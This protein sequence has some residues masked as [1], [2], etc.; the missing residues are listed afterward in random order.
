MSSLFFAWCMGFIA[1]A[2]V[3]VIGAS[4]ALAAMGHQRHT[5]AQL[6]AGVM[7]ADAVVVTISL[8]TLSYAPQLSW[9]VVQGWWWLWWPLIM[10]LAAYGVWLLIFPR[11]M[12]QQVLQPQ[13]PFWWALGWTLGANPKNWL[14]TFALLAGWH[15][16]GL[17]P[18][19]ADKLFFA[20][21]L[22]SGGLAAWCLWAWLCWQQQRWRQQAAQLSQRLV[23]ILCLIAAMSATF[24]L[25]FA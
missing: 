23:G 18:T 2:P 5:L 14:G 15:G 3:G 11:A 1:A 8:L 16:L 25:V 22:L 4:C 7:V 21:I 9:Q 20:L 19:A 13:Q 17:I 10:G 6:I 12:A 24:T